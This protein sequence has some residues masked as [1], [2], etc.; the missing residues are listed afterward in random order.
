MADVD[1]PDDLDQQ[2]RRA[3]RRMDSGR[4][5]LM[6]LIASAFKAGRTNARIA[7]NAGWSETR[8]K[9]IRAELRDPE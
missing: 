9:Q 7:R 6:A 2:I 5:D 8:I 4:A 1:E 3:R